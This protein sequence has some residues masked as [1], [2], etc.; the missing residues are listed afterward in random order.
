MEKTLRFIALTGI[1]LT[2]C[3][4]SLEKPSHAMQHCS[5]LEGNP[6][7]NPNEHRY[8]LSDNPSELGS[9]DCIDGY[10]SNCVW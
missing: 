4:L 5:L 3:W 9:C 6:C 1:I 8:C 7:R 2:T 10:W